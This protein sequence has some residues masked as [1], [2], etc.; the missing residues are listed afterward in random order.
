MTER[1]IKTCI[2]FIKNSLIN[3][4]ILHDDHRIEYMTEKIITI[5]SNDY[6]K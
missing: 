4:R 3:D 2:L 6:V 1:I 5:N